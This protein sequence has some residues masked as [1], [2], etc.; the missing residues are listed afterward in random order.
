MTCEDG[1][2]NL[3]VCLLG[4]T[5]P[6]AIASPINF[7]AASVGIDVVIQSATKYLGGHSDL[8]AGIVAGPAEVIDEV[9]R[10]ARL[11]GPSL[12]PHTAWLLDRGMRTLDLRVQRHNANAMAVAEWFEEGIPID[13]FTGESYR[14]VPQNDTFLL[15]SLGANQEDDDA[16]HSVRLTGDIVW[17]G[18][19][20][21]YG[22]QTQH[23]GHFPY[24]HLLFD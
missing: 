3:P 23:R 4:P 5:F 6:T 24:L 12:D 19:E 8:I 11:Y 22:E 14:Y 20:V 16:M 21:D 7:R 18:K 1:R 17:R 10:M 9:T 2:F 15:Y 13:P